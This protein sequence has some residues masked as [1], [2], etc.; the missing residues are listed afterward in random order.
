M[1]NEQF[2]NRLVHL[3]ECR[4]IGLKTL[5]KMVKFDPFIK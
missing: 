1:K 5:S 3:Y 2:K 4:G